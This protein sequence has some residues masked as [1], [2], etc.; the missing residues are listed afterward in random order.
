VN[1]IAMQLYQKVGKFRSL[2]QTLT[3]RGGV[4]P[5]VYV[6]TILNGRLDGAEA[7]DSGPAKQ[8]GFH[9]VI[10]ETESIPENCQQI[11]S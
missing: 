1:S 5:S 2:R 8:R 4:I 7:F 11:H 3:Q 6:I 10:G 9:I